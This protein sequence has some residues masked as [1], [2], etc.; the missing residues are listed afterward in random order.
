MNMKMGPEI[1]LANKQLP[2]HM[3]GVLPVVLSRMCLLVRFAEPLGDEPST[4][5]VAQVRLHTKTPM[6]A[7]IMIIIRYIFTYFSLP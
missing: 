3:A 5:D 4:A 6:N 7:S 2:A 1:R